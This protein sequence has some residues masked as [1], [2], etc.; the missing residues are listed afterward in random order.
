[1]SL[2]GDPEA[3]VDLLLERERELAV[4]EVAFAEASAGRGRLALVTAEAGGGKTALIE[5]FCADRAGGA[6]VLRGACDAL[7]TPRPLGPIHDFAPDAGSELRERLLGEAIPYQVAEA[8]MADI[9][10]QE[11]TVLVVEDVHW[12]DEATLDVLR[13]VARRIAAARVLIVL[14]YRD[15]A[16]D[17]RHPLR[18]MLGELASGLALTRVELAPLSPDAI[19]QLAEPSGIDA[20]DLHRVT[21]GNPFFVTEVLASGDALIP[22]TVRDAVLARAARLSR[23]GRVVLDAVAIAP[24][25]AELWLLEALAGEYVAALDECLSTGMLVEAAPGTVAFRHELA[26]LALED[27]LPPNRR[28]SLHRTALTSLA[29]PP[30]GPPDLVRLAHHAQAAR[31]AKAVL[32]YAPV[33]AAGAASVGAH[34]EAAGLYAGAARFA[35]KPATRADLLDSLAREAYLTGDFAEAFEACSEALAAHRA[36]G[37]VRKESASLRLRSRLLWFFGRS[38]DAMSDGRVAVALLETLPPE[39]GLAVAYANLA[40]LAALDED[41]EQAL[42]WG[43]RAIELA[44]EI[45]DGETASD[46]IVSVEGIEA[47]RG[48]ESGRAK[49]EHTLE[50]AIEAGYEEVAAGAFDFLVT[51]AVRS[52]SFAAVDRNLARGIDY[53]SERDLGTWRQSLVA[54]AARA[55]LDRGRWND[56]AAGAARVLQTAR[57]QASAPALARSVLALV[58]ARRGDPGVDDALHYAV[59]PDDASAGRVRIAPAAPPL[60][61]IYLAAARAEIAWLRADS[62]AVFAATEEALDFAVRARSPWLVGELASWRW[63]AGDRAEIQAD[64]AEPYALQIRGEWARAAKLWRKIGCPYEAALALADA[65]DEEP[66]RESLEL[67]RRLEARPAAAIVSRRLRA[68]GVRDIRRGPRPST[69]THAAGLTAREREILALVAEGLRNTEIAQRLFL[70]RRTVDN[71]VSAILRKLEA[72]TRGEAA[73]KAATLGLTPR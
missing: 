56:A 32:R 6:R 3:H 23:E 11:P 16:L 25:Q 71:H 31:D 46:A 58:R 65:N 40:K 50:A 47:L 4:L 62:A 27:S 28:I 67:L 64:A 21:G 48:N 70:S 15:Q 57:T 30:T 36:A 59:A 37:T 10:R 41:A 68:L 63:R 5:R 42:A 12:A 8:L 9:R 72:S 33:A 45:G 38:E 14:S 61:T 55:D 1:M 26:R 52:R 20:G 43:R 53:C 17:A 66:L 39:R 7:F 49:L 73:A 22:S 60:S 24:P 51:A 34:R 18:V 54:A 69:R 13:L 44:R 35:D 29:D 2:L 19:L